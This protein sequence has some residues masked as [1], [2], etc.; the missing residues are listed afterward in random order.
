[1]VLSSMGLL[2]SVFLHVFALLHYMPALL[3]PWQ[4][5]TTAVL[6]IVLFAVWFPAVLI[7]QRRQ[8]AGRGKFSWKQALAGCP[9]WMRYAAGGLMAYAVVNLLLT[10]SQPSGG[11]LG[12]WRAFSGHA[13]LFYGVALCIFTAAR[14]QP[15]PR[16]PACLVGHRMDHGQHFCPECGLPAQTGTSPGQQ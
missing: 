15:T 3:H 10:I 7:A 4:Q 14:A 11:Q 2:L 9:N 16:A 8:S 12:A 5:E 13:M 1:M 6:F